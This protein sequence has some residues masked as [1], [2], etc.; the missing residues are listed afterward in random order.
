LLISEEYREQNRLLHQSNEHYGVSGRMISGIIKNVI[1]AG[2]YESILDFGA[3][4]GT[5]AAAVAEQ[6]GY[7]LLDSGALYRATGLAAQWD[8]IEADDEPALARLAATLD[9]RFGQGDDAGRSWL[10]G[11]EITDLLRLESTG[12][13]ASR[14]SAWRSCGFRT[15]TKSRTACRPRRRS[16][17][18]CSCA[19]R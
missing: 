12:L 14:V 18:P 7:H 4:K 17:P 1:E 15:S 11:R 13:M 9:L 10:R 8:G 2:G 6:L 19:R 16:G 3:G 5:L